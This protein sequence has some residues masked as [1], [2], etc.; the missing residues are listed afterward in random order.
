MKYLIALPMIL[1]LLAGCQSTGELTSVSQI[2]PGVAKEGSLANAKLISDAT[3]GLE[4]LVGESIEAP[5]LLKFVIQQPVGETGSRSWREMWIVKKQNS[6]TQYLITFKEAGLGAADF[7]IEPMSS[8][9][10][11]AEC[12]KSVSSFKEGQS[13]KFILECLGEPDNIDKNPDG[14]YIYFYYGPKGVVLTYLF[15]TDDEL[16]KFSAYQDTN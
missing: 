11:K 15:D 16:I 3:E 5:N 13:N 9:S 10:Q 6:Q 8:A 7:Q 12:P 1:A 14:R 4:Q 2:K